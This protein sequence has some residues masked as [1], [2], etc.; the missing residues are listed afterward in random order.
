M[1]ITGGSQHLVSLYC[2]D[3][4]GT[5]TTRQKIELFEASDTTF[6]SP[7]DIH[8]L[9]LPINGVYFVYKFSGDK[10]FR[11]SR[12]DAL[13]GNQPLVSGIFFDP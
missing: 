2:V 9:L 12:T 7:L 1:N 5:G 11:I 10:K 8:S 6:S 13:A 3:W 4:N